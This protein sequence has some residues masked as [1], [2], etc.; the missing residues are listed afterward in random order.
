MY[1]F[2]RSVPG[3]PG[4]PDYMTALWW[5]AMLLTTVGSEYWPQTTEGR[6]LC[7]LLS[8]Y[9]VAIFGYLAALLASFFIGRDAAADGSGASLKSIQ[10]DLTEL[11]R[12]LRPAERPQAP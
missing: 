3:A 6:L 5:T 7:L 2:E 8:I 4:L 12:Q 10:Q 1:A 9:A 11:R